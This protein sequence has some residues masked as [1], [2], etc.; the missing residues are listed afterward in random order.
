MY[1]TKKHFSPSAVPQDKS[2]PVEINTNFDDFGSV[3]S[4][5][6]RATTLDAGN[7]K[8][9]FNSVRLPDLNC[10]TMFKTPPVG[11]YLRGADVRIRPR[12]AAGEGR[13]QRERARERRGQEDEEERSSVQKHAEAGHAPAGARDLVGVCECFQSSS[14]LQ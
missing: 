12:A 3:I 6:K 10:C 7:I 9:A 2:F 8:L 5:D 4:S 1:F 11:L 14:E 13:G